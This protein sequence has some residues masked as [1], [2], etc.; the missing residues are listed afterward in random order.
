MSSSALPGTTQYVFEVTVTVGSK[1]KLQTL[2][3]LA[4]TITVKELAQLF[5]SHAPNPESSRLCKV[6]ASRQPGDPSR[7]AVS[8]AYTMA[9]LKVFQ[10]QFLFVDFPE[11]IVASPGDSQPNLNAFELMANSRRRCIL[12][13]IDEPG[14]NATGEQ[15][16]RYDLRQALQG[17]DARFSRQECAV[18][19]RRGEVSPAMKVINTISSVIWM[20]DHQ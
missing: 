20:L 16:I 14:D 3:T 1:K 15:R 2:Q 10:F 6:T 12:P 19:T 4:S 11:I 18:P 8:D 13:P 17:T 7:T 9:D 5:S